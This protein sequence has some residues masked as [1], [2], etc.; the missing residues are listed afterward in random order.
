MRC[1]L[2]CDIADSYD[3]LECLSNHIRKRPSFY[4]LDVIAMLYDDS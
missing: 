3:R 2:A 1:K 4:L